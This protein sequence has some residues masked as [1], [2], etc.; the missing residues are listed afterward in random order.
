MACNAEN[1][2]ALT[3]YRKCLPTHC[4]VILWKDG[5]RGNWNAWLDLSVAVLLWAG[6]GSVL[7]LVLEHRV[8]FLLVI[9]RATD[10]AH[11]CLVLAI[12]PTLLIKL[13]CLC[14]CA[15]GRRKL[16]KQG[17]CPNRQSGLLMVLLQKDRMRKV[18]SE[19]LISFLSPPFTAESCL[20]QPPSLFLLSLRYFTSLELMYSNLDLY[21][22]H[23]KS[24]GDIMWIASI[25]RSII[26][27]TQ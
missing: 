8:F 22:F 24:S 25:P 6:W 2:C 10:Y 3:L 1:T 12:M 19:R 9:H 11:S 27:M 17:R 4:I 16:E 21:I 18:S 5:L 20:P 15:L 14:C 23:E 13:L 7:T 26:K